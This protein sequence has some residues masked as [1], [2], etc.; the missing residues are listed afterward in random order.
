[1]KKKVFHAYAVLSP[2]GTWGAG[3]HYGREKSQQNFTQKLWPEERN[4]K[5]IF[6]SKTDTAEKAA[7]EVKFWELRYRKENRDA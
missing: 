2:E 1:M 7:R 4:V 6:L 3:I 5:L